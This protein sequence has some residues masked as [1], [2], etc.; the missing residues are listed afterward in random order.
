MPIAAIYDIHGHLPALEAVLADI[1]RLEVDAILVGGDLAAGPMPRE[2]LDLLMSLGS[3]ARFIRGNADREMVTLYDRYRNSG[4]EGK[5]A[6]PEMD[7]WAAQQLTVTQ[8]DFLARL[9]ERLVLDI[10]KLGPVLFCHGSPRSDDE[11]ITRTTGERRMG[12]MLTGVTEQVIVCGHSHVQFDRFV[13]GKRV[14]NPGSVGMAYEGTPGAYW[15]L[16]GPAVTLKHTTYD[17]ERAA[18]LI[19]AT[20][21]PD[22]EQFAETI[23]KPPP[24]EQATKFFEKVAAERS[25]R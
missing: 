17:V 1:G 14:V 3:R 19:R 9:P 5:S 7:V 12:A 24:A 4:P 8:R 20:P 25:A 6:A 18:R 13:A 11:I 22:A 2:V 21:F 23:L 16:F 10:E 15:A